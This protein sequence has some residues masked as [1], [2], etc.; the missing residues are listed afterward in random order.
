MKVEY[1]AAVC[2]GIYDRTFFD[3]FVSE[4]IKGTPLFCCLRTKTIINNRYTE[5]TS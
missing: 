3:N 1:I 2:M 5:Y 4:A